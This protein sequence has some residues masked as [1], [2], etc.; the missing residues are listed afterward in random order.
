MAASDQES[1]TALEGKIAEVIHASNAVSVLHW[2][3]EVM[4]PQ[5]GT[6]ARSKARSAIQ[7]MIHEKATDEE[8]GRLL[9][10]VDPEALENDQRAIYREVKRHYERQTS[11]PRDLVERIAEATSNAHPTWK[12][13]KEH[14]EF[15]RFEA[16][17]RRIV[18]LKRE[19]AAA[20]D[21]DR[22]PYEVLIED[23]EPYL[24][25]DVID[26]NL[27]TLRDELVPLIEDLNAS[28]VDLDD[29]AFAGDFDTD[30]Q[31][32][33]SEEVLGGLG[34]DWDRCRL[35]LAPHPFVSG[36]QYDCRITARF[37]EDDLFDG[38]SST[39]HEGGHALYN[40]NIPTEYFGTPL[41]LPR[42]SV[43]HESQARLWENHIGRSRSFMR[44]LLPVAVKYFDELTDVSP[45]QAFEYVNRAQPTN[46][47]RVHA[48]EL[49][50]HLHI[51]IRYEIEREL[52]R[53]E[54]DVASVPQVWN[55][56]YEAYLGVRPES[57]SEGCL[58]DI[59]WSHGQIGYFPT[60]SLGSI[61]SAQ[62]YAVMA[63]DIDDIED[64]IASGD[65]DQ[66][67]GWLRES[68]HRHGQRYRTGRLIEEATGEALSA[69]Y[70]TDYLSEKYGSLYEL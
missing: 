4:M 46:P 42:D 49:A 6:P 54:L 30:H 64:A 15:E 61:L 20:I 66:L 60:Y 63:D 44:W 43:V 62:L 17:L 7:S 32:A 24:D 19:Y 58:Q 65:F 68:I 12:A 23:Y 22:D 34:I 52:M 51:V 10:E 56:K 25:I 45:A 14:D 70:F 11:V 48:D 8:I 53:G 38:L 35:D 55:D 26:R 31:L 16:D 9:E 21:P 27:R 33:L 39:I 28:P 36:N 13:A 69:T 2:D 40:L 3:Q 37:E 5:A 41:G 29:E 50:Y 57:D 59:H 67:T 47:I 1:Y 18:D